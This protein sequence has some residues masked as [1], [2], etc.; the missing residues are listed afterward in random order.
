V[1]R[2][3][4]PITEIREKSADLGRWIAA[5]RGLTVLETLIAAVILGLVITGVISL[6]TS[7]DRLWGR[8]NALS[9]ALIVAQNDVERIRAAAMRDEKAGDT[10]CDEEI[11]GIQYE[12]QRKVTEQASDPLLVEESNPELREISISVRRKDA[13]TE[14][15]EFM[16]VQGYMK[17]QQ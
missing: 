15:A 4:I 11:N 7:G 1:G 14:L 9:Q 6:L 2:L 12:L 3:K 13:N 10:I 17:R 16:L 8:R 5:S